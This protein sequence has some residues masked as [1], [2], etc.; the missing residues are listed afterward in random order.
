M[1]LDR[2]YM[3]YLKFYLKIASICLALCI[4]ALT[5]AIAQSNTQQLIPLFKDAGSD[6]F[7]LGVSKSNPNDDMPDTRFAVFGRDMNPEDIG[8]ETQGG[9]VT[10]RHIPDADSNRFL[11]QERLPDLESFFEFGGT[12]ELLTEE[13]ENTTLQKFDIIISE[14]LWGLDTGVRD[15]AAEIVDPDQIPNSGDEIPLAELNTQHTQWIELYNTTNQEINIAYAHQALGVK[16]YLLFTPFTSYPDRNSVTLDGDLDAN[17]KTYKVLDA[18]SNL[19]FGRWNLPGKS[20]RRPTTAFV[21]AYRK[22]DYNAVEDYSLSRAA[23]LAGIPFGSSSASW[24]ATPD[25][26]RRNTRLKLVVGRTFGREPN[27]RTTY[28][29]TNL[30]HV[31]TPGTAHVPEVYI[32]PLTTTAVAANSVVINE[33]RNDTSLADLDWIELKNVGSRTVDLDKWEI[34]IVTD[35]DQDN[36][37]VNLPAYQMARNEILLIVNKHPYATDLAAGI[38]ILD[39]EGELTGQNHKYLVSEDWALPNDKTFTLLLRSENDQNGK[40]TAIMDYAGNGFFAD[41]YGLTTSFWPLQAQAVPHPQI[42]ADFGIYTFTSPNQAWAR[43]RYEKNDGYHKEA[44]KKVNTQGGI[45]YAPNA[46]LNDAPG[47]PG[48]EN[49]ALKTQLVNRISP[50]INAEYDDGEISISEIMYHPG[51][52]AN[53]AQWIEIYNASKTQAID[54]KG[55]L[56]EIKNL[57]HGFG[58]YGDTSFE[59]QDAVILPSQTLLVV[60]KRATTNVPEN[61]RYNLFRHHPF[62]FGKNLP[63]LN[64]N[65]FHITLTD[66]ADP[67]LSG[68]N[69]IVDTVGNLQ[70]DNTGRSKAWDLPN[71]ATHS[72]HSIVRRYGPI[73]KRQANNRRNNPPNNGL[74][75]EGWRRFPPHGK[76]LSQSYYG[77]RADQ[78]SPGYRL[79]GPL[80]VVLFSFRPVRTET[81]A[82]RI[83]WRTASEVNNA[84]FNILRSQQPQAEFKVINHRGIIPGQGTRSEMSTYTYID[85]TAK[86]STIYY[87]RIEDVSFSGVRQTLATTRLKGDVSSVGKLTTLWSRFKREVAIQ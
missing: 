30:P 40:P 13:T 26:G 71:I 48:Y 86:P 21:S 87:Y 3:S 5:E 32:K 8:I 38:N 1:R 15:Q 50:K 14:I 24:A 76:G 84:G 11:A 52:N 65:G 79:G 61:T 34:S 10:Y 78:A 23:Q 27:D 12:V 18:I 36:D 22:I 69:I 17:D 70:F 51:E 44:W 35:Y 80:P 83:T 55:W 41:P 39:P 33:I 9:Q 72:R 28:T 66:T 20:G 62:E 57:E 53:L 29:L 54:L 49:D 75:A 7:S 77:S 37:L 68:D 47:T 46:D 43:I 74:T 42:L 19:L 73:Y 45:G 85:K 6:A 2:N 56:L 81:G 60:A 16:L 25:S 64:P 4:L 31:S 82:V 67:E 59:F 58:T 63:F